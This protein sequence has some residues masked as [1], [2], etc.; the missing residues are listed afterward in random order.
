MWLK[1]DKLNFYNGDDWKSLAKP[2]KVI[3]L[4]TVKVACL[5]C[6]E[7]API[8]AKPKHMNDR[9]RFDIYCMSGQFT[10]KSDDQS[11]VKADEWVSIL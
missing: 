3:D 7:R 6:D 8:K 5:H 11:V 1:N 10:M 4:K 9:T 2:R